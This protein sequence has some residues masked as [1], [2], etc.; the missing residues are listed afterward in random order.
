MMHI[1]RRYVKKYGIPD[2]ADQVT[3]YESIDQACADMEEVV[4][5]LWF[6]GT[7]TSRIKVLSQMP[8]SRIY[9]SINSHKII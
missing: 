5:V 4:D 6:S 8:A 2:P 1:S 7:R 9:L 3:G